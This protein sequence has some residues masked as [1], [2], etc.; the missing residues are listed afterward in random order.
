LSKLKHLTI[1]IPQSYDRSKFVEI[2]EATFRQVDD[3]AEGKRS[4]FHGAASAPPT[5][6]DYVRG[7]WLKNSLPSPSNY[8]GWICTESGSPGTWKGFGLIEG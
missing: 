5:T 1:K 2:L 3:L 4:A 7:D 6:G 8:F